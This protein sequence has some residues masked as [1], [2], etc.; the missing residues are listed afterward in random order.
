MA[1]ELVGRACVLP[2]HPR[3]DQRG[4][5]RLPGEASPEH[6]DLNGGPRS[7]LQT[8]GLGHRRGCP[9]TP[10]QTRTCGAPIRN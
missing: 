7:A 8:I 9:G 6:R 1:A 4:G 3:R 5:T 10:R 2:C